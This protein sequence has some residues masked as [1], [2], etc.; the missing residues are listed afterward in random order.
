MKTDGL[1]WTTTGYL[2][3]P[4]LLFAAGWLTPVVALPLVILTSLALVRSARRT[5][6]P[7][8]PRL[9]WQD[10]VRVGALALFFCALAG[11]GGFTE[12]KSDYLKHNL[13]LHDLVR[14]PHPVRYENAAFDNPF[15]CYSLAY[16]LPVAV[17]AKGVGGVSGAAVLHWLWSALGVG[18]MLA[19]LLR[20]GTPV[21]WWVVGGFFLVGGLDVITRWYWIA[22]DVYGGAWG[23]F[24]REFVLA[25]F[26]GIRQ[27]IPPSVVLSDGD[28]RH[29]LEFPPVF[30]QFQWA[31]QHAL[32]G[33][34]LTALVLHH[35]Y[36]Q[37]LHPVFWLSL[38]QAPFWSPFVAVGLLPLLA[39]LLVR[40]P[41]R[42]W[43]GGGVPLG[44]AVAWVA[45][46][47]AYFG[48][49]LPVGGVDFLIRYLRGPGDIVLYGLFILF[50]FGFIGFLIY[51]SDRRYHLLGRYRTW[52]GTALL[53]LLLLSWF[54]VGEYND[55]LLRSIIPGQFVLTFALLFALGQAWRRHIRSDWLVGL[56]G[57]FVLAA[58][59]PVQEILRAVP[60]VR[61]APG[62]QSVAEATT[63]FPDL[64]R[65]DGSEQHN[66]PLSAQYLGR[67]DSFFHQYLIK[68]PSLP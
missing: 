32:G 47:L 14:Y 40:L 27:Y 10:G 36:T 6:L 4:G 23:T 38:S 3:T 66:F 50:S 60:L 45:V 49:H 19:W 30:S 26:A 35:F 13:L 56:A 21:G 17:L 57:C 55:F 44:S 48:A 8:W 46:Y 53:S 64:S 59:Y 65:M 29:R 34:L 52:F 51:Q 22:Q 43:L 1:Y 31:P 18:L 12:Q 33:W 25:K 41:R 54:C 63:V 9:R 61:R 24:W 28:Y 20:L 42:E 39:V 7:A 5:P 62:P 11:V 15:L 37:K 68:P 58:V 16:Y 2:L 67:R